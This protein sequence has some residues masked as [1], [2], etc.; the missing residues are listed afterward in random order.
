MASP[1]MLMRCLC[2]CHLLS[3][4]CAYGYF[5]RVPPWQWRLVPGL[6]ADLKSRTAGSRCFTRVSET[7]FQVIQLKICLQAIQYLQNPKASL[8]D[9]GQAHSLNA[10]HFLSSFFFFNHLKLTLV[11]NSLRARNQT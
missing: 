8:R 11:T 6:K 5:T 7:D 2:S 1:Q 4:L 9:F 3:H 10:L